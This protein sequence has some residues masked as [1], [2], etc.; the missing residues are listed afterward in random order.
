[1]PLAQEPR[2]RKSKFKQ[3]LSPY[4]KVLKDIQAMDAHC[5]QCAAQINRGGFD[6]LFANPCAFFRT[7]AIGR[8][9]EIP[10]AIY[11]QEPNRGLYEALPQL[12]WAAIPPP[13]KTWWSGSY[14]SAFLKNLIQVQGFR[15]QVREELRNAQAFDLIL[16]NSLLVVKVF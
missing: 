8:Y 1:M 15:L 3:P 14:L 11:L 12:P 2:K 5:Q 7:T 4:Y 16:V 6:V 13:V 10:T 9:V